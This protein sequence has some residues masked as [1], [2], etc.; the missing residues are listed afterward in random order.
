MIRWILLFFYF[1]AASALL[2]GSWYL[3]DTVKQKGPGYAYIYFD[4]YS[5]ETSFW[6]LILSLI[7]IV[8]MLYWGIRLGSYILRLGLKAAVLPRRLGLKKSRK[9]HQTA[10]LAYLEQSWFQA[11]TD[12]SKALKKVE[13]PF[14]A[15]LVVLQAHLKRGDITAAQSSYKAAESS[16]DYDEMSLL[17]AN[18][19]ILLAKGE[20]DE[21]D[22]FCSNLLREFPFEMRVI[23]KALR[24]YQLQGNPVA[25][26]PLIKASQKHHLLTPT[27]VIQ[28]QQDYYL[29]RFSEQCKVNEWTGLKK[30][31]RQAYK[32]HD[33]VITLAFYQAA[34]SIAPKLELEKL[35]RKQLQKQFFSQLCPIY[36]QLE[37]DRPAQIEFLEELSARYSENPALL[38]ALAVLYRKNQDFDQALNSLEK[39]LA[40]ENNAEAYQVLADV[41][42]DQG[43]S[44]KQ[45]QSLQK[46]LVIYQTK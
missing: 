39:S 5:V 31:W 30:I 11:H 6:T 45:L 38:T 33:N 12:M 44:Q 34:A 9:L 10:I 41:Y 23:L 3:A 14:I 15:N 28:W 13:T 2:S 29:L 32:L 1:L 46:A 43:N 18:I 22:N 16:V 35:L 27:E 26:Q 25:M 24:V 19:D 40:I 42:A 21:A 20:Y 17:L 36:A 37:A 8:L 4:Q 7:V